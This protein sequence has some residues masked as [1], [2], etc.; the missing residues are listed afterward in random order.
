MNGFGSCAN[1]CSKSAILKR[2]PG[3]KYIEHTWI[4]LCNVTL[5]ATACKLVFNSIW[6]W[7]TLLFIITDEPPEALSPA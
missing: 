7:G 6:L 2:S 4:V 5:T 1:I 3:G